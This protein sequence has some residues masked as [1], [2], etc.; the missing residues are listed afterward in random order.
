MSVNQESSLSSPLSPPTTAPPGICNV[1]AISGSGSDS[2]RETIMGFAVEG[3]KA[4]EDAEMGRG[5]GMAIGEA[6]MVVVMVRRVVRRRVGAC[7][8]GSG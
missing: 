1:S 5:M 6:W 7:M 3:E 8:V 4:L 2:R